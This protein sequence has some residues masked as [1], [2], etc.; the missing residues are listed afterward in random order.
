[1]A[2][3]GFS[4]DLAGYDIIATSNGSLPTALTSILDTT[5]K[6]NGGPTKTHAL[7]IGSPAIDAGFLCNSTDQRG[8][9]RLNRSTGGCDIGSFELNPLIFS[10]S[11]E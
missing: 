2:F 8:V 5:L 1:M 7:V 11:F 9:V 6:N 3:S 10:N 4:P